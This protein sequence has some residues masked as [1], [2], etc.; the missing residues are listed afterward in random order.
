MF[1]LP[2]RFLLLMPVALLTLR[3]VAG[4]FQS[5]TSVDGQ[6]RPEGAHLT[7]EAALH[8]AE[9]EARKN[10]VRFSDFLSPWFRYSQDKDE[11]PTW[12]FMYDGKIPAIGNHFMIVVNDRTRQVV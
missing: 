10:H 11:S 6:W 12:D 7:L 3:A 1:Q 9:A 5:V 8:I 2:A 4:D